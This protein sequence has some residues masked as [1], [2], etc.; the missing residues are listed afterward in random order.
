MCFIRFFFGNFFKIKE[1]KEIMVKIDIMVVLV[2]YKINE[3]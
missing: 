2:D 1:V 3:I